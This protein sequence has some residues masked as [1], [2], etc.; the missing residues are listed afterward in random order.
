[1]AN[2][3][4]SNA[5]KMRYDDGAAE[6]SRKSQSGT[7][8]RKKHI[9]P[10]MTVKLNKKR[11]SRPVLAPKT[12]VRPLRSFDAGQVRLLFAA[13]FVF[14]VLISFFAFT[15]GCQ[16][17]DH[18]L[19]HKINERKKILANL[20]DDYT[21][22]DVKRQRVWSDSA[23]QEYAEQNLGMQKRDNHQV[24]WFEVDWDNDFDD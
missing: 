14:F 23:L 21:G 1:M 22:L 17:R 7:P 19:T 4:S 12:L 9:R 18:E 5:Y 10:N 11:E 8:A 6:K 16:V 3:N 15:I 2:Y 20:Q 24:I 13:G